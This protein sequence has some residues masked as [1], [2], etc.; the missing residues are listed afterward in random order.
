[1]SEAVERVL[2]ERT[3]QGFDTPTESV[4]VQLANILA[5]TAHADGDAQEKATS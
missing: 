5:V 1:M 3:K 4:V 2:R